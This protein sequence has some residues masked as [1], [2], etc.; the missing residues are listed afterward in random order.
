VRLLIERGANVDER[1]PDKARAKNHTNRHCEVENERSQIFSRSM[2]R[3]AGSSFSDV[4]ARFLTGVLILV[5][6]R[7]ST[8]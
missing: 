1:G 7:E 4:N 2:A 5:A 8:A 3:R 6:L